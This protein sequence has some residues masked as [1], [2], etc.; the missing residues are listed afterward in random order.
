MNPGS[1]FV[2]PRRYD[3]PARK[4]MS[5]QERD[6]WRALDNVTRGSANVMDCAMANCARTNCTVPEYD[7]EQYERGERGRILRRAKAT[8]S[9]LAHDVKRAM[10]RGV[11]GEIRKASMRYFQSYD[12]KYVAYSAAWETMKRSERPH[13]GV[14]KELAA[15]LDLFKLEFEVADLFYKSRDWGYVG[16]QRNRSPRPII[17]PGIK[18]RARHQMVLKLL[19]VCFGEFFRDDQYCVIS[20]GR[21]EAV[22]QAIAHMRN[23]N[24]QFVAECDVKDFFPSAGEVGGPFGSTQALRSQLPMLPQAVIDSSVLSSGLIAEAAIHEGME[25]LSHCP[26]AKTGMPQGSALSSY[27]AELI[28][29]KIM[30]D[31]ETLA[32]WGTH[33]ISYV[34][35]IGLFGGNADVFNGMLEPLV[36]SA[37][38][39][40]Y[41]SFDLRRSQS[42]RHK[43][44]GFIYLGYY[45]KQERDNLQT[46]IEV[47]DSNQTKFQNRIDHALRR[48]HPRNSRTTTDL[49]ENRRTVVNKLYNWSLNFRLAP[50]IR[51]VAKELFL[52]VLRDHDRRS[53]RYF[54]R[55][56]PTQFCLAP[57]S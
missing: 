23:P 27:L 55:L 8:K 3:R 42:I 57:A 26:H 1:N 46:L 50:D 17:N 52:E 40:S 19:K 54:Q 41:G 21:E 30:A 51:E 6:Q 11:E 43:S 7:P 44:Q 37:R 4:F 36:V 53:Q 34:D 28:M 20:R 12:A 45:L 31:A 2:L 29:S 47:S 9:K 14:L 10:V 39:S 5:S 56:L 18:H 32:P 33:M 15:S 22:N 48:C 25:A 38:N 16:Q 13:I 35:N 49:S 24:I